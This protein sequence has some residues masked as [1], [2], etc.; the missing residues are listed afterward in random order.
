M[1]RDSILG[2]GQEYT[3]WTAPTGIS[4]HIL[5]QS[6]IDFGLLTTDCCR[7]NEVWRLSTQ[8]QRWEDMPAIP[9]DVHTYIQIKSVQIGFTLEECDVVEGYRR[10]PCCFA[11]GIKLVAV[12]D[13]TRSV[14]CW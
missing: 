4:T 7:C 9:H 11:N 6:T 14:Y 2:T 3:G 1:I 10:Y 8:M 13:H 5:H 12:F